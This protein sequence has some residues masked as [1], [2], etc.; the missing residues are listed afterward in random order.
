MGNGV[1]R[2]DDIAHPGPHSLHFVDHRRAE[3]FLV[4]ARRVPIPRRFAA[5]ITAMHHGQWQG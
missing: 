5:E 3:N 1:D 2:F 4:L